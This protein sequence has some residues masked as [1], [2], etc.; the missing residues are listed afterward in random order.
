MSSQSDKLPPVPI[1]TPFDVKGEKPSSI[2]NQWFIRLKAKVDTINNAIAT[3]A[4]N[5]TP[6]F[7]TSDGSGGINS[8]TLIAGTNVTITNPDGVAGNPVISSLGGSGGGPLVVNSQTTT[9]Y[10]LVSSDS[11]KMI[12]MNVASPM[13]QVDVHANQAIPVGSIIYIN[14]R[15]AQVSVHPLSGSITVFDNTFSTFTN[16][17]GSIIQLL[18]DTWIFSGAILYIPYIYVS[19]D[20]STLTGWT[21]SG[22]TIAS[23]FG[24]PSP[25]FSVNGVSYA[26]YNVTQIASF[27]STRIFCDVYISSTGSLALTNLFFGCNSTG[28]G[29]YARFDARGGVNNPFI[30]TTNSWTSWNAPPSTSTHTITTNTWYTFVIKI[31]SSGNINLYDSTGLLYYTYYAATFSG[32]YLAVN[33]Q[34]AGVVSWFDNIKVTKY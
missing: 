19:F 20:G 9:P 24:N 2:W 30:Y 32:T 26:T 28:A 16:T 12:D 21:N 34:T 10:T 27:N 5:S 25:S 22:V 11:M 6:G 23:T 33:G 18:T 7:L 29:F 17:Y 31:D 13:I 15:T 1:N 14:G 3:I 4:G 8:R